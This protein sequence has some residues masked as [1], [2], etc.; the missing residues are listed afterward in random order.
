MAKR[1]SESAASSPSKRVKREEREPDTSDEDAQQVFPD[2]PA[3]QEQLNMARDFIRE[4]VR[5]KHK[6]VIVPDKDADGLSSGRIIYH[7]LTAMGHPPD[8]ISVHL[9]AKATPLFEDTERAAL[10]ALGAT[11]AI[12]LDQG[13]RAGPPILDPRGGTVQ[14][15]ILDHHQSSDFP[16]HAKVVSACK[17]EPIAT[18][19]LLTYL[20]CLPLHA[21]VR[22]ECDWVAVLGVIGD[23]GGGVKWGTG[24]WPA[25][26][27]ETEKRWTKKALG[28]AVSMLNAPRRTAEYNVQDAWNA[29]LKAKEPAEIATNRDLVAARQRVNL[30]VERCTHTPPKFSKDGRVALFRIR[31]GYQVHPV[32]AT[33]WA[34]HLKTKKLQMIMVVNTA[35]NPTGKYAHFSCRISAPLRKLPDGERPNLIEL[36]QEYASRVEDAGFMERNGD[37][38]AKGHKEATGG[39]VYMDDF[40]L[41]AEAMEIG[42]KP[43]AD[44]NATPKKS[45]SKAKAID[46]G[47]KN[48][49]ASYFGTPTKE[50]S[51][52]SPKKEES[53]DVGEGKA[54]LLS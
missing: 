24:P 26:L 44:P 31:S 13:S 28:D 32:I 23:L 45:K 50:G 48:T 11:R 27:R 51:G 46:P 8:L 36:L 35:Y 25:H 30:E 43:D 34:G 37:S 53:G 19:S 6:V 21:S 54:E 33:R 40:E 20:T 12:V 16:Q 38:F 17:S 22:G 15:L 29:L 10:D 2:W 9:L 49:L 3:P 4:C 39:L 14:T 42:V 52:P 5:D 41:L 7:T 47:Q 1:K 18:T